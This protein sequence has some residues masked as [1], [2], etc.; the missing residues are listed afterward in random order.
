MKYIN[1]F[2]KTLILENFPSV[3]LGMS[4]YIHDYDDYALFTIN[5]FYGFQ[6]HEIVSGNHY[7][8]DNKK[9]NPGLYSFTAPE[10]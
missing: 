4:Y 1:I 7:L 6:F 8:I 2:P 9:S 5:C 10:I 3:P